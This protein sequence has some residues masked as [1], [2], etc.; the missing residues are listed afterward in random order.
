M[1]PVIK[2]PVVLQ[3]IRSPSPK[4]EINGKH[5]PDQPWNDHANYSAALEDDD[6][7]TVAASN[8]SEGYFGEDDI[9][10]ETGIPT[11]QDQKPVHILNM[12][13]PNCFPKCE[14]PEQVN[15]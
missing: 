1:Q 8:V 6:D 14:K 9:G 13:I 7:E 2:R 3:P 4:F 12:S 10:M 15:G 11:N 5:I